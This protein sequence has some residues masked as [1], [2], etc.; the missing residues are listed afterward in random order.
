MMLMS[1]PVGDE[2]Q[3]TEQAR[4]GGSFRKRPTR[5]KRPQGE[6]S[7]CKVAQK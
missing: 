6:H 4:W 5:V 3:A 1:A 7:L 2:L